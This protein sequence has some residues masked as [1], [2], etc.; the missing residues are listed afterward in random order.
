MDQFQQGLSSKFLDELAQ[1]SLPFHW[2]MPLCVLQNG[3]RANSFSS[4]LAICNCVPFLPCASDQALQL[5]L[6]LF[7][8]FFSQAFV[9]LFPWQPLQ[10]SWSLFFL[11]P[12]HSLLGGS[13]I[14][15]VLLCP[16]PLKSTEKSA[17]PHLSQH[18]GKPSQNGSIGLYYRHDTLQSCKQHD[19]HH[20][21]IR[22]FG[23]WKLEESL[24][25]LFFLKCRCNFRNVLDVLGWRDTCF[26]LSSL[27]KLLAKLTNNISFQV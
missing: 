17:L 9:Q 25:L 16:A 1:T 3:G 4:P 11:W 10:G 15:L 21:I 22:H 6:H 14:F 7:P 13:S 20:Q 8:F 24:W 23:Q 12:I 2:K 18:Q 19:E 26:T 5:Q 27:S